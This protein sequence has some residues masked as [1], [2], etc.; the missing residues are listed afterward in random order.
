MLQRAIVLRR[1]HNNHIFCWSHCSLLVS[2]LQLYWVVVGN[3]QADVRLAKYWLP[4]LYK[5]GSTPVATVC[6][7]DYMQD[8]GAGRRSKLQ[9]ARCARPSAGGD[10]GR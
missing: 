4:K 8:V 7:V 1:C 5:A 2:I 6:A 3:Q 9:G 10:S